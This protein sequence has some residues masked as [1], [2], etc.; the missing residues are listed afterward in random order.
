MKSKELK[1]KEAA[2]RGTRYYES[3]SHANVTEAGKKDPVV[4]KFLKKYP[5]LE[6]YLALF[7]KKGG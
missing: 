5:T 3:F 2:E 1:R 4:Q 6:S 7:T